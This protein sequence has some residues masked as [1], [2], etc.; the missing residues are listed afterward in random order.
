MVGPPHLIP[1]RLPQLHHLSLIPHLVPPIFTT[2]PPLTLDKALLLVRDFL[3]VWIAQI[4]HYNHVYDGD[5]FEKRLYLDLVVY[6]C[7]VPELSRFLVKFANDIIRILVEKA[8][9]GNVHHVMVVIYNETKLHVQ[10]RYLADF[11]R[12]VGLVGQLS[13]LDFLEK[14]AEVHVAKL[15]LPEMTWTRLYNDMRSLLFAHLEELKRTEAPVANELF[16]K[17]LVNVDGKV[18]LNPAE[19]EWIQLTSDVDTRHTRLVPLAEMSVGF[20]SFDLRNEYITE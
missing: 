14:P 9:G 4:L 12:F 20:V 18:G 1:H 17:L 13:S 11:S 19:L 3:V 16:Y 2:M 15:A 10:R 8:G 5:A 6:Q 7:R